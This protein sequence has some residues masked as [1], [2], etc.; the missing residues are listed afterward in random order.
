MKADRDA[1]QRQLRIAA[2]RLGLPA[3]G[4]IEKALIRHLLARLHSWVEA[5]GTP[6]NLTQLLELFAVSMNLEI[7]EI[8]G[9]D[10]LDQLLKRIPPGLEPV[11][12]R[13]PDEL[14]NQTDAVVFQRQAHEAWELPFFAAINCR[15]WHFHRRYFS[16]WHEVV[17]LL[18]DGVQLRFAFRKTSVAHKH[19]EEVLVDKI[20]SVLA[21][22][23]PMFEP[24]VRSEI[25][26]TG[27]L[28]F[29]MIEH[30]RQKVAPDASRHATVLACVKACPT[31]TYFLRASMG[32]KRVE[33]RQLADLL[34][35][36]TPDA[37]L[38]VAKLR[39]DEASAND[40]VAGLGVR[41]HQRMEVPGTSIVKIVYEG[42]G[43]GAHS[44]RERLEQWQTSTDGPVGSGPITV[45][46]L[47]S[48]EEVWALITFLPGTTAPTPRRSTP[49]RPAR[50]AKAHPIIEF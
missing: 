48:R 19:P 40:A 36:I 23:P 42:N 6:G 9:D 31:P 21:F 47:R 46:A 35:P 45:E 1:Y 30:V 26:K 16:K 10:D 43:R 41:L 34:T 33:E 25:S 15:S 29:A 38:P 4:D 50:E 49:R 7:V 12:A 11:M 18:L 5:H 44:S 24:V 37:V 14:D 39:I 8:H 2:K 3:Q 28:T 17:H 20:A 22:Y 32:H 13:L 27:G